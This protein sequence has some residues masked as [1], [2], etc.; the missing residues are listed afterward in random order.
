MSLLKKANQYF[1]DENYVDA[2]K[3]YMKFLKENPSLKNIISYNI[4]YI[5]KH[6][7]INNITLFEPKEKNNIL[8]INNNRY[9]GRIEKFQDNILY[10]WIVNKTNKDT[11]LSFDIFIDNA[12]YS[13]F[14]C[15]IYRNDLIRHNK[16][17]GYGG[18]KISF[19]PEVLND[20]KLIVIDLKGTE[21]LYNIPKNL[22]IDKR[23]NTFSIK[24]KDISV[25]VPIYNAADDVRVCIERFCR[26]TPLHIELILINDCSTDSQIEKILHQAKNYE[27]YLD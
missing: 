14:K 26:Y 9:E 27:K 25:I 20:G 16:S 8:K 2:Y 22:K 24:K 23:E 18:F 11:I 12:Y 13:T 5:E 19:S 21:L 3:L 15:D 17:N 10:G 7:K 4:A 1:R 6:C